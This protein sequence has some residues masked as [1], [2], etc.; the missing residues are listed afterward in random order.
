M[1]LAIGTAAAAV[2]AREVGSVKPYYERD[3]RVSVYLGDCREVLPELGVAADLILADPPYGQTSLAWD[4]WPDGWPDAARA[5]LKPHGSMWC[6]GP[7]RMFMERAAD[8]LLRP[9]AARWRFAQDIVWEKHNGSSL[10]SDRFKRVHDQAVHFYPAGCRWR[11]VF[12][13]PVFVS[14]A[15]KKT[16]RR[17]KK[18]AHFN[19]VNASTYRSIAGGP[20]LMRSVMHVP[21]CH[22]Y[23]ENETQKPLEVVSPLVSY[24]CPLGGLVVSPF[25]GSGTDGVV[26][27]RLGMRAVLIEQREDQCEVAAR[28]LS[29]ELLLEPETIMLTGDGQ[30]EQS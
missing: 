9:A 24:S 18:P 11:D 8:F 12:K 19:G 25:A 7:A 5:A 6:F 17:Q 29:Q 26:A 13:A 3:G 22:G 30:I 1:A 20:L 16:S 2:V 10:H 28:R 23:A 27:L 15:E 21:S 14:G 4:K